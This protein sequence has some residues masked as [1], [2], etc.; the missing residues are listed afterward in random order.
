M[1]SNKFIIRTYGKSEYAMML[2]P[3]I[4]DPKQAQDKLLRWIKRDKKFH[5]KLLSLSITPNDNHYN[6]QQIRELVLKFG[7]PGEYEI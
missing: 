6:P 7:A 2:F 5:E 3:N 4:D 1:T